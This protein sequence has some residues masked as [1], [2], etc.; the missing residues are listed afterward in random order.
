MSTA[1]EVAERRR[2]RWK[3]L[4]LLVVVVSLVALSVAI[5][6]K[7]FEDVVRVRAE[8]D[9]AGLQLNENGD[10]RL[11]GALVG[12]IESVRSDGDHAE[13]GLA[14]RAGAARAVP[15]GSTVRILPT[16]LFGQKYVELVPPSTRTGRSVRAGEVLREDRGGVAIEVG[17]L[18]DRLEPVLVAV[19]P[20]DLAV[21]LDALATGLEGRGDK[22]GRLAVDT[23][24]LLAGLD[25]SLPLVVEDLALL[26]R[27]STRYAAI[28]PDLLRA[29]DDLSV[30][31]AT[32]TSRKAAIAALLAEVTRFAGVGRGFLDRN[33]PALASIVR[34]SR[35]LTRVL[36]RYSP[37]FRCVLAGLLVAEKAA[38]GPFVDGIFH[39]RMT[40]GKQAKGYT[41][42]DRPRFEHVGK[43]PSCV[44]LPRGARTGEGR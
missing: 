12:R 18:L 41:A 35:P 37:E 24:A 29:L 5:Y 4:V 38:S 42:A 10:V 20:H 30:T 31:S 15:A 3:G 40:L 19:R 16:T 34:D 22:I 26:A 2:L 43:G 17:A 33:A 11:R 23:R 27:V 21:T 44:G 14:L 32:V 13:I 25:R 1:R 28:A 39:V 9:R 8:V 6:D 7:A 36:A